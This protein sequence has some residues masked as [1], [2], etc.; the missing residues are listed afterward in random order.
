[1]NQNEAFADQV[2]KQSATQ[3]A[4]PLQPRGSLVRGANQEQSQGDRYQD[5]ACHQHRCPCRRWEQLWGK[6]T[7]GEK[8]GGR[9]EKVK[10]VSL[11]RGVREGAGSPQ[12]RW[13][14]PAASTPPQICSFSMSAHQR[15][16]GISS[17]R[18]ENLTLIRQGAFKLHWS[19]GITTSEKG[20]ATNNRSPQS[21]VTSLTA[22]VMFAEN[23]RKNTVDWLHQHLRNH[24]CGKK[25]RYK[26]NLMF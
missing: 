26:S 24:K 13:L 2:W 25:A 7:L 4:W 20:V 6:V 19:T 8:K 10:K 17:V 23:W 14:C 18:P 11:S 5:A 1:M 3:P 15:L 22:D 16:C 21:P 12:S 9:W